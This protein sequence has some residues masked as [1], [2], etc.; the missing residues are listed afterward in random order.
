MKPASVTVTIYNFFFFSLPLQVEVESP[1]WIA[2]ALTF[3]G[4]IVGSDIIIGWVSDKGKATL[5]VRRAID[6]QIG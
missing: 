2:I 3:R 4:N 6:G 5:V 1:G